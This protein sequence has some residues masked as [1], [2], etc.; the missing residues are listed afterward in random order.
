[1][2]N[3]VNVFS[4]V[5]SG[6]VEYTRIYPVIPASSNFLFTFQ[7]C[8]VENVD[9]V[10]LFTNINIFYESFTSLREIKNVSVNLLVVSIELFCLQIVRFLTME[11]I[12][13][14]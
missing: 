14:I 6:Q 8:F 13:I 9:S 3:G 1:M 12:N 4:L 11:C 2:S 10:Q 5:N 7:E